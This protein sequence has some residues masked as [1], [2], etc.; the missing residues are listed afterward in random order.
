MLWRNCPLWPSH[1]TWS[2][3]IH[4]VPCDQHLAQNKVHKP[5]TLLLYLSL[6][7]PLNASFS[8]NKR[9]ILFVVAEERQHW[10]FTHI[11]SSSPAPLPHHLHFVQDRYFGFPRADK[12]REALIYFSALAAVIVSVSMTSLCSRCCQLPW[13]AL[14]TKALWFSSPERAFVSGVQECQK[15]DPGFAAPEGKLAHR[16][17][18]L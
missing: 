10:V 12:C 4:H 7:Q 17:Y 14:K 9:T 2:L 13:A 15:G 3:L 6:S 8:E 11:S 16:E 18:P 1:D 5:N